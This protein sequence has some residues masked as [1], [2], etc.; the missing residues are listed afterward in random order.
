MRSI[1]TTTLLL[2]TVVH[3]L[4]Q[5]TDPV[6]KEP[7]TKVRHGLFGDLTMGISN[8]GLAGAVK[9][10]Y[11]TG[12]RFFSAGYYQSHLCAAGDYDGIPVWNTGGV[13]HHFSVHSYAAEFG[14]MLGSTCKQVISAGISISTIARET[15]DPI[16]N[17]LSIGGVV[18]EISG[19]GFEEHSHGKHQHIAVGIPIE[20]T[21][22]LFDKRSVGLDLSA[23][24]DLNTQMTFSAITVGLR[25]GKLQ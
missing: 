13:T 15:T 2:F 1:A 18:R 22:F 19:D 5:A 10:H 21:V 7:S 17:D 23:R 14:Y 6:H 9:M 12:H 4:A 16:L 20:Y 3:A 8:Y 11:R 24:V 25:L